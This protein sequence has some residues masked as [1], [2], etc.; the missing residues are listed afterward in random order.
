MRGA[1]EEGRGLPKGSGR[2]TCEASSEPTGSATHQL[3]ILLRTA[4][5][6]PQLCYQ[7]S[8]NIYFRL[9]RS[10]VSAAMHHPSP[11]GVKAVRDD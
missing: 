4:H 11:L 5:S 9:H 8:D 7:W 3:W 1:Y 6:K 10:H 2:E